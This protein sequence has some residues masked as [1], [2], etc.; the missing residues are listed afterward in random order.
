M[1]YW[2]KYISE[3]V[4]KSFDNIKVFC[5]NWSQKIILGAI[6]AVIIGCTTSMVPVLDV[7]IRD[8]DA[9]DRIITRINDEGIKTSI[10]ASGIIMV[11]DEKAARRVRVI[12]IREDLIPYDTF[13]TDPW[14]IFDRDRWSTIPFYVKTP[15]YE[16]DIDFGN[17]D[18]GILHY[19]GYRT[20]KTGF[21]I[22]MHN[23]Y[24]QYQVTPSETLI[25]E[26]YYS[27]E[28]NTVLDERI[29]D[30]MRRNEI[31]VCETFYANDYG[32]FTYIVNYS[33]D[34]YRTFGF[35]RMASSGYKSQKTPSAWENY[36][37]ILNENNIQEM[38]GRNGA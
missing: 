27:L 10:S 30:T 17:I 13:G 19:H 11:R 33:F 31:N 26:S 15:I 16:F 36:S 29:K 2:G 24:F 34:N 9:Q 6:I 14:T 5:E 38:A 4:K 37:F 7:P 1:L 18:L 28:N 20:G 8:Q 35:I 3:W 12:L 23:G 21:W 25:P 22:T 32:G